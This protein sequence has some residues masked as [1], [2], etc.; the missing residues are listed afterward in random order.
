MLKY[1]STIKSRPYLYLELKKAL[2]LKLQGLNDSEIREKAIEENIFSMNSENRKKEIASTILNRIQ[3][4]DEFLMD[5]IANGTLETSK[6]IALYTLLKTDLLF[7]EF[8]QEVY[9]EKILLNDYYI[10]DKDFNLFFQR[11]SE[12]SERVASW[13]DYTYYKLKQVYIRILYDAGFI[14]KIDKGLEI[15]PPI[16]EKEVI[17]HLIEK[18]DKAYIEAMLGEI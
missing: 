15:K 10:T 16:I 12:Q 13:K 7:F 9:R 4:L 2:L 3:V 11:K 17:D 1:S 6:Q 14:K 5:K 18:N 8:M